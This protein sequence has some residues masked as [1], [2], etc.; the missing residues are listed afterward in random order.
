MARKK[1]GEVPEFCGDSLCMCSGGK[2]VICQ[3]GREKDQGAREVLLSLSEHAATG[4]SSDSFP[5]GLSPLDKAR[6][7]MR[8]RRAAGE[9]IVRLDPIE[10]AKRNPKSLRLA[11]TAKCWDCV[12]G[13]ADPNP[14]ARI[15]DCGVSRCSLYPVRPYQN[16]PG[17][18]GFLDVETENETDD[19]DEG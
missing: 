10:K 9:E 17:R 3:Q 4:P 2:H 18:S 13:M 7:A 15:R 1:I 14:R 19:S 8:A 12:G 16:N 11:I 6:A 5:E